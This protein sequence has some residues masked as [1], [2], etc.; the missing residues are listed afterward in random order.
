MFFPVSSFA[1]YDSILSEASF[2]C[3]PMVL[4]IASS[5]GGFTQEGRLF[6]KKIYHISRKFWRGGV[7]INTWNIWVLIKLKYLLQTPLRFYK[8]LTGVSGRGKYFTLNTVLPLKQTNKKTKIPNKITNLNLK[9]PQTTT[10]PK[11]QVFNTWIHSTCSQCT[12]LPEK[13]RNAVVVGRR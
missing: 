1:M 6:H 12:N 8:A 13:W 7:M 3:L 11:P 2:C 10:N 9:N 4:S 5:P